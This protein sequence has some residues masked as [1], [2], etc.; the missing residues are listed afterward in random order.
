MR[1]SPD[2]RQAAERCCV[3]TDPTGKAGRFDGS[4]Y[5]EWSKG[6][7]GP[8]CEECYDAIRDHY[9]AQ[10]ASPDDERVT[11]E[12]FRDAIGSG[13]FFVELND[14]LTLYCR[15]NGGYC[16]LQREADILAE[17]RTRSQVLHV[18]AALRGT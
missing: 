11:E 18:I 17:L 5:I 8:L 1:N 2:L 3:C 15:R 12:W 13:S 6:A 9:L 16:W 14:Q 4:L 10:P 7:I